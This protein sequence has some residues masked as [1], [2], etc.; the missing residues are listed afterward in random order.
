MNLDRVGGLE[1]PNGEALMVAWGRPQFFP[2]FSI[3]K[4]LNRDRDREQ[5]RRAVNMGP[6]GPILAHMY[7]HFTSQIGP[8]SLA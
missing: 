3:L 4:S 5:T 1:L 7:S 8:S 2:V 6:A